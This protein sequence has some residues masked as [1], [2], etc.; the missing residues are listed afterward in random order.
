MI[1]V[2]WVQFFNILVVIVSILFI[3]LFWLSFWLNCVLF[4]HDVT[5]DFLI[6]WNICI[7]HIDVI[8]KGV[9]RASQTEKCRKTLRQNAISL[10]QYTA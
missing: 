7:L 3:C 8:L 6:I 5:T 10:R 2:G 9:P 4:V 1:H